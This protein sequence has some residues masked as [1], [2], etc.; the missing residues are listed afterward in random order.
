MLQAR[1]LVRLKHCKDIPCVEEEKRSSIFLKEVNRCSLYALSELLHLK[2]QKRHS[3]DTLFFFQ[4]NASVI[5]WH[6]V[7]N[8]DEKKEKKL[9]PLLKPLHPGI[10][11]TRFQDCMS[12]GDNFPCAIF[13]FPPYF[14]LDIPVRQNACSE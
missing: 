3:K 8:S 10:C 12:L 11:L 9:Q 14:H 7:K 6:K 13:A 4:V 1:M 5:K 2:V